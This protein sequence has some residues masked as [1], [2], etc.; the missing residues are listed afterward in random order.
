M[1]PEA[2]FG[3]LIDRRLSSQIPLVEFPKVDWALKLP[4]LRAY[5][6]ETGDRGNGESASPIFGMSAVLV[7]D[8]AEKE[9]RA[10]LELLRADFGTPPSRPLSWK[11][12]I[13]TNQDRRLRAASVL[14][15]VP[16]LQVVHVVAN[17]NQLY[18]GSYRDDVTRFYNVVAYATLQRILW[19]ARHWRG[20]ARQ[21]QVNFGHVQH[22][23]HTDTHRY[24]QIKRS[25]DAP[26]TPF[27]LMTDLRWIDAQRY[28]M[29]QVADVYAGFL[30]A[31]FWPSKWGDVDGAHLVSTWH[32]I[33]RSEECVV[34]LGLQA[35]P[36]SAWAKGM[37]WWPC[38]TCT[39][40][41]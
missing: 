3:G 39:S 6:D 27:D 8:N 20:G 34:T 22:H 36:D 11:E 17:K 29:S 4:L 2:L 9:A 13:K 23:D 16:G 19:A 35:R 28:E 25:Q 26:G 31:A 24:F 15:A 14:R 37:P 32:Q 10:A 5:V 41:Y 30:K 38:A 1:S 12:D 40:R 21:V 33:R 18:D 7:D